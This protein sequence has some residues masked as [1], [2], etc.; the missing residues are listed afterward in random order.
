MEVALGRD[1]ADIGGDNELVISSMSHR[2]AVIE[3][4]HS[5][6]KVQTCLHKAYLNSSIRNNP[7]NPMSKKP[8]K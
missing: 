7:Q 4:Q 3:Q 8:V 6:S 1:K 2:T 5:N